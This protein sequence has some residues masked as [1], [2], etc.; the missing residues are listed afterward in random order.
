MLNV[1][2]S[3]YL[4]ERGAT[5]VKLLRVQAIKVW[6]PLVYSKLVHALVLWQHIL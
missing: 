4:G 5:F 6:E 3:I 2:I 1:Y